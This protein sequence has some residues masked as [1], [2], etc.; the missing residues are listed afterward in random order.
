ML[1]TA[2][3]FHLLKIL[4]Q[5]VEANRINKVDSEELLHKSGLIKLEENKWKEKETGAILTTSLKHL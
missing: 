1:V 4:N 3:Y 5:M 2:D